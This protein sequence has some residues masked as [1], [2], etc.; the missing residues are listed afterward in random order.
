VTLF[1]HEVC[2]DLTLYLPA[3]WKTDD[4]KPCFKEDCKVKGS[5]SSN[6]GKT[7]NKYHRQFAKKIGEDTLGQINCAH[8]MGAILKAH[9]GFKNRNLKVAQESRYLVAFTWNEGEEPKSGSGTA[10]TWKKWS[11][12]EDKVGEAVHVPLSSLASQFNSSEFTA[13]DS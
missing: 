8:Y 3:P 1:L 11:D 12:K 7:S 5:S 9:E 6:P 2:P 4:K 10:D 13:R